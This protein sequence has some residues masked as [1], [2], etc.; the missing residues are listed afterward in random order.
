MCLINNKR[1]VSNTW[2][3]A[4]IGKSRQAVR[5]SSGNQCDGHWPRPARSQKKNR[6]RKCIRN[7][8]FSS[9]L[10]LFSSQTLYWK[11]LKPHDLFRF[12]TQRIQV[13]WNHIAVLIA[14]LTHR[15]LTQSKYRRTFLSRWNRSC[16]CSFRWISTLICTRCHHQ[17]VIW[18]RY[19][20]RRPRYSLISSEVTSTASVLLSCY[21]HQLSS[22]RPSH[23]CSTDADIDARARKYTS[24]LLERSRAYIRARERTSARESR[25]ARALDYVFYPS[26]SLPRS[27]ALPHGLSWVWC[28]HRG[29]AWG[30]LCSDETSKSETIFTER[31]GLS[32]GIVRQHSLANAKTGESFAFTFLQREH[33]NV[34]FQ[35]NK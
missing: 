14:L 6:L 12:N 21:V 17:L 4:L 27:P 8:V 1:T 5:G 29:R 15:T 26:F 11:A 3:P 32:A 13:L 7:F 16:V 25:S 31:A 10:S 30:A 19:A 2:H 22:L 34:I 23:A 35:C 24:A 9:S 33:R 20:G 18:I 28:V